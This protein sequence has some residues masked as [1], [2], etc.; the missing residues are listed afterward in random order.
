MHQNSK[1]CAAGPGPGWFGLAHPAPP[2]ARAVSG[3]RCL[4]SSSGRGLNSIF[5]HDPLL[6]FAH[7]DMVP[8]KILVQAK[9]RAWR[10]VV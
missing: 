5:D 10:F 2:A 4:G 6:T 7:D 3:L 8:D 1:C 9:E